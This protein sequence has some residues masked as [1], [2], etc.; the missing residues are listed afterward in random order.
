VLAGLTNKASTAEGAGALL[1]LL[2]HQHAQSSALTSVPAALEAPGGIENLIKLG[3]P[4]VS[5]VFGTRGNAIGDA[6]AS[7][8][9]IK[10]SSASS[11]LSL[12]LPI[13]L[14]WIGKSLGTD[15]SVAS[16]MSLLGGQ[17]SFLKDL[18]S[19]LAGLLGSGAERA[20]AYGS[21]R[22]GVVD[23]IAS[24]TRGRVAQ[25]AYRS[26]RAGGLVW[27]KW[28]LPVLLL[29][30]LIPFLN[31]QLRRSEPAPTLTPEI[32]M[33]PAPQAPEA[34]TADVPPPPGPQEKVL[35]ER[36]DTPPA[37]SAAFRF[38]AGSVESR[39]LQ[40]IEDPN[41][42]VDETTWFS[43]R[44]VQFETNSAR[45]RPSSMEQLRNVAAVLKAYPDVHLKIGGYTDNVGNDAYNQKLSQ[46]RA[47]S[48]RQAILNY[49]I[50]PSRLESGGYGEQHPTA[51]NATTEGRQ[52]NRRIDVRVTQK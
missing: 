23:A 9:G 31:A 43:L 50:D 46:E 22:P 35:G 25:P 5:T 7:M 45:L 19:G 11:L 48:A 49:G 38:P 39:L 21:A 17:K 27:W 24:E 44:G 26:E 4:L 32:A 30:A 51:D 3:G 2:T 47:A 1:G 36:Q 18:P 16:L 20:P 28:L 10:P 29:L 34:G 37:P 13:V 41:R 14:G 33:A 40:F 12:A 8:S 15:W 52:Q 42:P 6:V